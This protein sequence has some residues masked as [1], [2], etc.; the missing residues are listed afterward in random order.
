M[1][2]QYAGSTLGK[3]IEEV[4]FDTS[5][6]SKTVEISYNDAVGMT[7]DQ[8]RD[9]VAKIMAAIDQKTFPAA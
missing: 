5:T 2:T 7:K 9:E 4:T 6:T 3:S 8:L 1:A